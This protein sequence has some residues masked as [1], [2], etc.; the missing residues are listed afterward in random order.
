SDVCSSDLN[1]QQ[2]GEQIVP[3]LRAGCAEAEQHGRGYHRYDHRARRLQQHPWDADGIVDEAADRH[4]DTAPETGD[5][6]ESDVD[7]PTGQE[8]VL[9]AD[10][11]LEQPDRGLRHPRAVPRADGGEHERDDERGCRRTPA[12][13]VEHGCAVERHQEHEGQQCNEDHPVA[14]GMRP[15]PACE[16]PAEEDA[17]HAD[18]PAERR[19]AKASN[20]PYRASSSSRVYTA[21][22]APRVINTTRSTIRSSSSRW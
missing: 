6:N 13:V 18:S 10:P 5:Q 19:A 11:F 8:R 1:E 3:A 14:S 17:R 20:E 2:Q 4:A 9:N 12:P 16:L 21:S 7:C 15:R 22:I